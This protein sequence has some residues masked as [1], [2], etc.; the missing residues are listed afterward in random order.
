M[1]VA[2][3]EKFI[4]AILGFLAGAIL[5]GGSLAFKLREVSQPPQ[6][7]QYAGPADYD[8]FMRSSAQEFP[9]RC[10]WQ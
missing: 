1:R 7:S 4:A 8:Y 10:T 3:D 6:R 2:H 9:M 5:V